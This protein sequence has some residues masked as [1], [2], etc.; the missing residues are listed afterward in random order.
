MKEDVLEQIVEDYLQLGGYFTRHNV[1]FNPPHDHLEY[2][3]QT[4]SVSS[5]I[6]V[7]GLHPCRTGTERV[8]VVSCKSWQ[9]GFNAKRILGQLRGEL[10]D[11]KRRSVKLQFR[12]LWLGKWALGFRNS[13]EELTGATEFTYCIAV[14]KL[15]GNGAAWAQ[16][17][18]IQ[19]NLAG[20]PFRF[21]TLAEIWHAVLDQTTTTPATS[22]MG[23]LAQLLRAAG[24]V[25]RM[26]IE[27][28]LG[29]SRELERASKFESDARYLDVRKSTPEDIATARE[30]EPPTS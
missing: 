27:R 14:T 19:Q 5:D 2:V 3:G 11:L 18:T 22:E 10:P 26:Q 20:N 25:D 29:G 1:R 12:E 15:T 9:S 30:S 7:V 17:S 6:D 24:L 8:M 28:S 13:I 16:D 23:R 4:D 21:L